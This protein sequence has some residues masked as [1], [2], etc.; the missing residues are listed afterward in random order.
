MRSLPFLVNVIIRE[1]VKNEKI[2]IIMLLTKTLDRT[3]LGVSEQFLETLCTYLGRSK[4]KT[5][6][7]TLE[8]GLGEGPRKMTHVVGEILASKVIESTSS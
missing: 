6:G 5:F 4:S 7:L 1:E 2:V 3:E 8:S